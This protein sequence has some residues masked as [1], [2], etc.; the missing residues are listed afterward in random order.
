MCKRGIKENDNR[1]EAALRTVVHVPFQL[2]NPQRGRTQMMSYDRE[3][4]SLTASAS[5]STRWRQSPRQGKSGHKSI[6][7][8]SF[9]TVVRRCSRSKIEMSD[10]ELKTRQRRSDG[11]RV[12]GLLRVRHTRQLFRR[13]D[14]RR[15]SQRSSQYAHYRAMLINLELG[16]SVQAGRHLIGNCASKACSP[17]SNGTC[18]HTR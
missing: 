12:G 18:K 16:I 8:E 10:V 2:L 7:A 17:I 5:L 13:A 3:R 15:R 4:R 14:G 9:A 6:E 11:T 1:D